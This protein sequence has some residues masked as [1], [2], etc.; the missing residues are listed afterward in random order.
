LL[1][2]ILQS[3]LKKANRTVLFLH[4]S[5]LGEPFIYVIVA[6][7][8]KQV[9]GFEGMEGSRPVIPLLRSIFLLA[10]A[11]VVISIVFLRRLLFSPERMVPAGADVEKIAMVYSRAQ[12]VVDALAAVPATLGFV[13][14]L[15]GGSMEFLVVLSAV[16]IATL[17]FLF[18]RY[19][20][21]EGAVLAGIGRGETIQ[22]AGRGL[23]GNA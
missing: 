4:I 21:L 20:T 16:S 2:P 12:L 22:T 14:F 6:L 17:V 1:D 8:L 5:L 15:L 10:S 18:P 11:L 9:A 19:E 23:G 3:E 13:L 7:A